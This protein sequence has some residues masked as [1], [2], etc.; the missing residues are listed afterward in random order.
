MTQTDQGS[1][2]N[3]G[4]F[5]NPVPIATAA[6]VG[7][8]V[9]FTIGILI[10][11][12]SG[13]EAPIRVKNGS[14]ELHLLSASAGW[15]E[16]GDRKNWKVKGDPER[17]GNDYEVIAAPTN[18]ASCTNGL[19]ATG[20]PVAFTDND[21]ATIEIRSTGRKTK[22]KSRDELTRPTDQ[23][24]AQANAARFIREIKVGNTVLCTFSAKDT[25]LRVVLIDP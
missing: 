3:S 17:N 18:S 7:I 25:G 24:I 14:I 15:D 2:S 1:G 13:D 11:T 21:G 20:N 6:V 16:D 12:A 23:M 4:W 8:L 10:P 9:G 19:S 22:V 5:D